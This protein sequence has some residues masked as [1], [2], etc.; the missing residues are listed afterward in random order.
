MKITVNGHPIFDV[1]TNR[2]LTIAE[3]MYVCGYD[4]TDADDCKKGYERG[5]EGFYLDDCGFYDFDI[6]AAVLVY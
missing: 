4:I 6:E 5:I 3:A 1:L 2:S